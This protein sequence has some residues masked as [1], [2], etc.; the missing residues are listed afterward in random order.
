MP[1]LPEVETIVRDLNR[2]LKNKKVVSVESLDK[3][4]W[5]L[6]AGEV[7]NILGK[8]IKAVRRRAKMIIFDLADYYL[9][10]HLKMTGQLVYKNKTSVIAGDHP[11]VNQDKKLP[12]QFTRVIFKFNDQSRLYF[13]DVRRFGWIKLVTKDKFIEFNNQLGIEPLNPNFTLEYFNKILSPKLKTSIKQ[14]L[15]DQKY[16]S[17]LGNIYADESLFA[18]RIKPFR[19]AGS[20]QPAE[21]KKLWQVIPKILRS[22][23]KHRGTSFSDYVDAQGMA[24]NFIKY[25]KVYG[26]S[27]KK[28]K[29]CGQPIKKI[30]LGGRGTHWCNYCQK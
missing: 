24:G 25:L 27:G 16:I 8:K 28:C 26:R 20:L 17:G 5:Q 18:A 6:T 29:N 10:A 9:I 11:I 30:K 22:A 3:K 7:K 15:L 13:N 12:S 14:I 2:K 21:I 19:R 4:V 23:I 1:E